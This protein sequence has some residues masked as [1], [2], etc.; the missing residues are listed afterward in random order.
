LRA[1]VRS[2]PPT[3]YYVLEALQAPQAISTQL[4]V[5][6]EPVAVPAEVDRPQIVLATKANEAAIDDLHRWAA[7]LG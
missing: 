3:R 2:P 1:H 7:P 5:L 6:V 4:S